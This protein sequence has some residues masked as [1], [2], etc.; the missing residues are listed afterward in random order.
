MIAATPGATEC[1]PCPANQRAVS[2]SVCVPCPAGH[3]SNTSTGVCFPCPPG[4]EFRVD[5]C[6]PCL[7]GTEA[8]YAGMSCEECEAGTYAPS[9][10]T[11]KC[12]DC[13]LG[14]ISKPG[15][16][17]VCQPCPVG[18]NTRWQ[19]DDKCQDT[20]LASERIPD[21]STVMTICFTFFGFFIAIAVVT[22]LFS[23]K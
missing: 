1:T 12:L 7:P 5:G 13:E 22:F 16:T 20:V 17:I 18:L 10:G 4:S 9:P 14:F 2:S 15:Q 6:K 8:P 19:G 21:D 3:Y 23:K 11:V